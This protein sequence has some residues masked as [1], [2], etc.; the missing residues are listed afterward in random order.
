MPRRPAPCVG[1][2]APTQQ[3][4]RCAGHHLTLTAATDRPA[5]SWSHRAWGARRPTSSENTRNL[6]LHLKAGKTNGRC[7][8][9]QPQIKTVSS[10]DGFSFPLSFDFSSLSAPTCTGWYD[11]PLWCVGFL[12]KCSNAVFAKISTFWFI[13]VTTWEPRTTPLFQGHACIFVRLRRYQAVFSNYCQVMRRGL[14]S[15]FQVLQQTAEWT[16]LTQ[17]ACVV[18]CGWSRDVL[19]NH[20]KYCSVVTVFSCFDLNFNLV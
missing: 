1:W 11:C 10:E 20:S 7:M 13:M 2:A 3:S 8:G 6:N 14:L 16:H 5:D 18:L 17:R 9:K 15:K 12:Q 4:W 19:I